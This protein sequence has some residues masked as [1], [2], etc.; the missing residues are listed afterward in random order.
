MASS[1]IEVLVMTDHKSLQ[2]WYSEDL[3]K[4]IG[5]VGRRGRWHEF[6]SQFNLNII[7]IP[8]KEHHV[9]DALSRW[10]Y[11]AGLE[12]DI[13]FHGGTKA[14]Q[15]ARDCDNNEHIYDDFPIRVQSTQTPQFKFIRHPGQRPLPI[16]PSPA[17]PS[18]PLPSQDDLVPAPPTSKSIFQESWPYGEDVKSGVIV[19][20]FLIAHDRIIF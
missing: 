14:A 17:L 4:M 2:H 15:C 12:A 18:C 8:G 6:L 16:A 3:N 5:A 9:S 20:D 13:S 11:P 7:Y 1:L 10:A 19:K